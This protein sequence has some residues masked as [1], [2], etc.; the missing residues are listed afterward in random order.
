M[1]RR[2]CSYDI[3]AV[4]S[5][6]FV[7]KDSGGERC[8]CNLRCFCVWSVGLA[9][10]PNLS[11]EVRT[12]AYPPTT[13][14]G[15]QHQFAGIVD[16]ARWGTAKETPGAKR[17][18]ERREPAFP[19]SRPTRRHTQLWRNCWNVITRI[20]RI[21]K[22]ENRNKIVLI[23]ELDFAGSS[24]ERLRS[25]VFRRSKNLGAASLAL[26]ALVTL[27]IL[28]MDV[29]P[30]SL[31]GVPARRRPKKRASQ[32]YEDWHKEDVRI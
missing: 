12:N 4:P 27:A 28:D 9:A 19:P 31:S 18:S 8:F 6:S 32:A 14:S 11:R 2:V 17:N 24:P 7:L 25:R 26:K 20:A 5:R 23:T 15:E 10:S 3:F 22:Q 16:V 21:T 30:F 13:P 1:K 29:V